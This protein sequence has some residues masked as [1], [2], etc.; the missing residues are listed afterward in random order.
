MAGPAVMS[1]AESIAHPAGRSTVLFSA[2][3]MRQ[4]AAAFEAAAMG[5]GPIDRAAAAALRDEVA[6]AGTELLEALERWLSELD[7]EDW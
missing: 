7:E 2:R 4:C 3:R 5:S 1:R 6:R